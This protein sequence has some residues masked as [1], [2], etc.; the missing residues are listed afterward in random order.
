MNVNYQYSDIEPQFVT[1]NR[2][3][4]R[5]EYTINFDVEILTGRERTNGQ[6]YRY[7]SVALPPGMYNRNTVISKLVRSHYTD[8]DMDAVRLNYELAKD[9][10]IAI[11]DEKR[12]E[13]LAEYKTMQEWRIHAKEIAG[14]F[15]E[16]ISQ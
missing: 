12:T 10:T 9:D 7:Q 5:N 2:N 8:D 3:L 1:C 16:F 14:K 6:K 15:E 4:G 13:Y 11:P